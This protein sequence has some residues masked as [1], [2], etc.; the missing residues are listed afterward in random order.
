[1]TADLPDTALELRS[2][3]TSD[4]TLEISLHD[5][6]VPTPGADEVLVRVEASPIN[7]SD[8]GLLVASAD[9]SAAT[10]SGTATRPVVTAPVA[11]A[12]LKA[13]TA[14]LDKSLPVGNE[15]AG[16]VVAAGSSDAAQALLGKTVAIAGGA[17]YAQYRAIDAA[18]CLVLPD[19]ATARDGA[20]SFVN[21][22]TALG[23]TE[24]LRR[25]GHTAL[26]H[27]AA[28]SNLGQMLVKLCA[29][30]GIPL[31]NI[32]RKPEQ[33]QLLRSLGAT[34]VL[35]S[36]SP[37]FSADLVEA[38]TATSATLAFDATGGGTLA[39]QI[40]NA[41]EEAASATAWLAIGSGRRRAEPAAADPGR[42]CRRNRPA[43]RARRWT[44]R[45]RSARR[46]ASDLRPPRP[47][48]PGFRGPVRG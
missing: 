33:E 38:L 47:G 45:S 43:A 48:R 11:Q 26:V 7:P 29:R 13:L 36:T 39:S 19:G 32:V 35:N 40:L 27:T 24:T 2:L 3:V 41:M 17:M 21:P 6:P 30:D 37:S 44:A 25:E 20:A 9:L 34:H 8:L 5:V 42:C 15:G 14:R 28:A 12:S 23:M 4:G 46:R 22:M 10:V 31:V 18:A 16:T 1:M